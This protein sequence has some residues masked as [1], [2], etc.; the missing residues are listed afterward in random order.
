VNRVEPQLTRLR[1]E[2]Q[3]GKMARAERQKRSANPG[4]DHGSDGSEAGGDDADAAANSSDSDNQ[5]EDEDDLTVRRS[6]G[7]LVS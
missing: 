3:V 5:A 4:D 2:R 7:R 6:P 1:R